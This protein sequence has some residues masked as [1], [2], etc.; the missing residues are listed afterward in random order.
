VVDHVLNMELKMEKDS[1]SVV[2]PGSLLA[3]RTHREKQVD[4]RKTE[5]MWNSCCV[6][7]VE[8]SASKNLDS[9]F[10]SSHINILK[11]LKV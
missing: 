1:I 3:D 5:S 2:L 10:L 8:T 6:A 4:V 9:I 7:A 11:K